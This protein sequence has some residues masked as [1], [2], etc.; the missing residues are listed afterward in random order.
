MTSRLADTP[1]PTLPLTDAIFGGHGDKICRRFRAGKWISTIHVPILL[2][3]DALCIE[4]KVWHQGS[5]PLPLR[6]PLLSCSLNYFFTNS[7]YMLHIDQSS[8]KSIQRMQI[9]IKEMKS[10]TKR[11]FSSHFPPLPFF[12]LSTWFTIFRKNLYVYL[13][14]KRLFIKIY[15]AFFYSLY[16]K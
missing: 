13:F 1:P 4:R 3:I 12:T 14:T 10:E 8:I 6:L 7:K 11:G 9:R 16:S 5:S 15:T 2:I